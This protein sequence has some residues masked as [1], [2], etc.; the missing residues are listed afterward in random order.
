M[1][2]FAKIWSL[3][4]SSMSTIP[5]ILFII[6]TRSDNRRLLHFFWFRSF[7]VRF[8][9]RNTFSFIKFILICIKFCCLSIFFFVY[10][11]IHSFIQFS[12]FNSR[13]A[14]LQFCIFVTMEK[15]I[16]FILVLIYFCCQRICFFFTFRSVLFRS[17]EK[18]CTEPPSVKWNNWF[19]YWKLFFSPSMF[20][21]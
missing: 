4:P 13:F 7:S 5:V 11:F 1:W 14:F 8:L 19:A 10:S 6:N 3:V 12:P 15:N 16:H 17:L 20:V 9:K 21:F 2:D 18:P